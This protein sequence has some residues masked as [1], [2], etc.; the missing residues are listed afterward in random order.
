M[1]QALAAASLV[2]LASAS[3]LVDDP[4][5]A[6]S[7]TY[8][9]GDWKA[10]SS[11]G[12]SMAGSVPGDVLTDL[13]AAGLIGDPLY[14]LNFLN[15]SIWNNNTWTYKTSFTTT[16]AGTHLLVFDGIK[17]GARVSVNG[18]LLAT[19][20][21]QFMRYTFPLE[22][23]VLAEA[24]A[25]GTHEL[26]VAFDP[27]IDCAGRWMAC[28]GGWDWAPYTNTAQDGIPT[29]TKGIWKSV[30]VVTVGSAAITAVVPQIF[31]SGEY[32]VAPLTDST[33]K[34]FAVDVKVFTW[35]AKEVTGTLAVTGSW[36]AEGDAVTMHSQAVT[37]PKGNSSTTAKLTAAAGSVKLWW[38]TGHGE[39]PLYNISVRFTPSA[40]GAQAVGAA[41]TA[42]RRVGFRH[43]AVVTG[44]DTDP[45][46]VKASVGKDGTDKLGMLWRI[47]GAAIFSKG[48]NM[49]PMEELEGRMAANAHRQL[50]QSAVDGGMNTLRVWGGGMFLPD[51][52]YDACDE[53]GIM[54]YHDMQYA[55][56]G[57]S[58][59]NDAVQDAELRHQI[60]RLSSHASIVL[61]DGCNE[62]R[63]LIGSGTG[64]YATFVMTVVAEEDASRS[65]WPSCP[66]LG[67]T[68]GVD[69]LT[70]RPNGKPLL[71]PKGGFLLET[72][73]PY[74]HGTGFPA[75]N[76]AQNLQPVSAGM[77]GGMPIKLAAKTGTTIGLGKAN[78]FASEFGS[79][80]YSSFE[81]MA[82]TLDPKHWSIHGGAPGD[83]CHGGFASKCQGNNVMSQRNYPCDNIID[84]YFGK[85]DFDTVGE[86]TF[87]KQLWQCMVG[88]ALLIKSDIET[89]RSTNQFGI[90]VWQ[91]NE[92]WPT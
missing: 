23:S 47:N 21:D 15:A 49:I 29:F 6:D 46:Y 66:A 10:S 32:P 67:W 50:V 69:K 28:T 59:K 54:V 89:R 36:S 51:A 38:P 48:A 56:G 30:S 73:G 20:T 57:H 58:P 60:R 40:Q 9:D 80:V 16:G 81:S 42:G 7:I 18:K 62:C 13:Q 85:S 63:V 61:W 75:V 45:A 70:A 17:M 34:G 82:P 5:E 25:D 78:I 87:K 39:Q 65:I 43:F 37:I 76:G 1:V 88:Q 44:D 35:A 92:I 12:L 24:G 86:L 11:S 91:F 2:G 71:T 33:H 19:T 31:Y 52:W 4:I 27:A 83:N 84:Q 90:I 14:E 53:L 22:E 64:I 68:S 77:N 26:S 3:G 74:Q 8:L 41:V 55:Q 72:H 79:S